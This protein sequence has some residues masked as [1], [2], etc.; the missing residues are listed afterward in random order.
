MELTPNGLTYE[1]DP[2]HV[3]LLAD[4]F[5]FDESSGVGTP[6][7]KQSNGESEASKS[8]DRANFSICEA[9]DQNSAPCNGSGKASGSVHFTRE[10]WA[11][12]SSDEETRGN[13]AE[14]RLTSQVCALQGQ[15]VKF[16]DEII[17]S[18]I[19]PCADICRKHP[20]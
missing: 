20:S 2:R 13:I 6:G 15:S 4:D 19:I 11:D 1:A 10:S 3:D 7:V 16:S 17:Y 9:K 18:D 5:N 8:L 14:A 12:I